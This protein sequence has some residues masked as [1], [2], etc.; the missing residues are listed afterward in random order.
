MMTLALCHYTATTLAMNK[1][2][3]GHN[4]VATQ[5]SMAQLL[6]VITISS[7]VSSLLQTYKA[8]PL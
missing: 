2:N 1:N 5:C 6:L 7:D 3:Q 4:R 8:S